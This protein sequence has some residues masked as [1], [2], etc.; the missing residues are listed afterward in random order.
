MISSGL[1]VTQEALNEVA[2]VLGVMTFGEDFLPAAVRTEC[3][4]IITD[5]DGIKPIDATHTF[6]FLKAHCNQEHST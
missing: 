5:V 4:R 3:E 1:P 6:Q 2:E